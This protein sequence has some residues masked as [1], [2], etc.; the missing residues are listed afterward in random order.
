MIRLLT[1]VS[2]ELGRSPGQRYRLEQWARHLSREHGIDLDFVPFESEA[3]SR[4][5]YQ[6]GRLAQKAVLLLRDM[7]RR[8]L[9]VSR[10][11][12]YDGVV[13]YREAALLGPALYEE[14]LAR[15]G[16][17]MVLDFDDAVWLQSGGSINGFFS[18][19]RF[20]GKTARLCALAGSV[21]VGNEFL[22]QYARRYSTSVYVVPTTIDL[23]SYHFQP[24]LPNNGEF[25][26]LWSGSQSTLMYLEQL[27]EPIAQLARKRRV[28]VRIICNAPPSIRFEGAENE[29][30]PWQEKGEAEELGKAHVGIMPLPDDPFARGKCA[31]KALQYM[32]VGLPVVLSPVGVNAQVVRHG[33]N[34][35][36]ARS[37]Q[38]WFDA[39][40]TLAETPEL[41]VRLGREGRKTVETGYTA[42]IGA[43]RFAEAV[44]RALNRDVRAA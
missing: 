29:F 8:A 42:E 6:R 28:R 10:V 23:E 40:N 41:R 14:I 37:P 7:A 33:E 36:W 38:E 3:L 12:S 9:T 44:G 2:K 16:I 35:L 13:V 18:K 43:A 32:A 21:S 4:V 30:V 5:L 39:L 22:A 24:Q 11:R 19:L 20:P 1:L 26:I 17:P 27:R 34:G 15:L 25:I 31:L